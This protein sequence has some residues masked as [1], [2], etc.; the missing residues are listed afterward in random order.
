MPRLRTLWH[1]CW[2]AVAILL[3]LAALLFAGIGLS[4]VSDAKAE[5]RA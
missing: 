4:T 5:E 2:G 3:G 1:R